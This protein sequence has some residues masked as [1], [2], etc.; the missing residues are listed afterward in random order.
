M[1]QDIYPSK[2][3]NSYK[4]LT[5]E[6]GDFFFAFDREGKILHGEKDGVMTFPTFEN[7]CDRHGA[8]SSES[9]TIYLF[10]MDEDRFF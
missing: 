8:D 3:N 6:S 5:P 2:L 1:I 4:N 7:V 10:S 9:K